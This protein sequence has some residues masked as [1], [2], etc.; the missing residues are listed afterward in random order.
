MY[1]L[2][3][4]SDHKFGLLPYTVY[5]VRRITFFTLYELKDSTGRPPCRVFGVKLDL[6]RTQAL[7]NS[8]VII[9][10]LHIIDLVSI[11][12]KVIQ[13]ERTPCKLD[14]FPVSRS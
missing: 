2:Q 14:N 4:T 7:M 9:H 8:Y 3:R 12:Q 5:H 11:R 6:S 10:S 1:G 13:I